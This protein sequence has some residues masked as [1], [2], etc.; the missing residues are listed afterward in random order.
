MTQ[1]FFWND[2]ITIERLHRALLDGKVAIGASDTV[3]GLLSDIS[4]EGF[5]SLNSIKKKG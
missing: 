3:F 1:S 2:S 4:K 5:Q